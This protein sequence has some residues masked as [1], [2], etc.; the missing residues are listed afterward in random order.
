MQ[1]KQPNPYGPL[2]EAALF[3]FERSL[4]ERL[5]EAYRQHL[6]SYNGGDWEPRCFFI[7]EE[8]GESVIQSTYGLHSGPEYCRLDTIRDT[9]SD[10]IPKD[11]LAI[12]CDSF[13]NQICI[14]ISGK[15]KGSVFF[16]DHEVIGKAAVVKISDSFEKFS[17]S[18][19][20]CQP[21]NRLDVIIEGDNIDELR[22]LLDANLINLDARDEHGRTLIERAAIQAKPEIIVFLFERGAELGNALRYAETNAEFFSEHIPI[23]DLI[24]NLKK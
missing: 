24:K 22:R 19:L 2:E 7:S 8:E 23:V 6:L 20:R 11:L 21:E 17:A 16:W 4:K 13:G 15:Q 1:I 10:R 5:P 18:L 14:A 3:A 9:F 12:A